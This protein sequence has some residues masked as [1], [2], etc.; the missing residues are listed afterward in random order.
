MSLRLS[1]FKTACPG[2]LSNPR[3]QMASHEVPNLPNL[4][5]QLLT[6]LTHQSLALKGCCQRR[7]KK[8]K[9]LTVAE[10]MMAL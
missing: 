2:V 10:R 1:V 9:P 6:L 5:S 3:V 8:Q 4:D 7:K